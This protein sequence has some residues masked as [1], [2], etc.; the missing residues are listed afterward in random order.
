MALGYGIIFTIEDEKG[1]FSTTEIRLPTAT[2]WAD[3]LLMSAAL[4]PLID[5][6]IAGAIRRVGI[7]FDYTVVGGIKLSPLAG[8]DVEEGARFQFRTENNFFTHLRLPTFLESLIVAGTREVDL[9]DADV[10]AFVDAMVD[11]ID[12]PDAAP[13]VEPSDS[14][15]EDIV[16]LTSAQEQFLSSRKS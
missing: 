2:A 11:G 3:V 10:A 5:A 1:A 13:I 4:V 7:V 15:G 9:T 6:L 12:L 14:R 16:A 8:S